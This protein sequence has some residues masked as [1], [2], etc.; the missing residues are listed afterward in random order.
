MAS[1]PSGTPGSSSG[2]DDVLGSSVMP[3]YRRP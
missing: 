3:A 1:S 2:P